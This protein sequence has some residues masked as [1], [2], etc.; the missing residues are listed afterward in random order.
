M[1]PAVTNASDS[2][3]PEELCIFDDLA[4]ALIIDPYLGFSTHK[5]DVKYKAPKFP[6]TP[7]KE[8]VMQFKSNKLS[9]QGAHEKLISANNQIKSFINRFSRRQT[10]LFKK[11]CYRYLQIFDAQ[12][13]FEIAHCPRYSQEHFLGAKLCTTRKWYKNEKVEFLIGCIAE[14][15][16]SEEQSML[17]TGVNDFSVMYSCRKN[18][19]QLWLG[20]GAFINHDCRATCK[21]VS[22]GRNTACVKILRDLDA[23]D[24]ITCHYGQNFFGDDNCYCECE[25]CERRGTGYFS[26]NRSSRP[27]NLS[28][29]DLTPNS[30]AS[31]NINSNQ[32]RSHNQ[33]SNDLKIAKSSTSAFV[34]TI[35]NG[36]NTSPTRVSQQA[37]G[38]SIGS[39]GPVIKVNYSLRETDNRLRRLKNSIKVDNT[40]NTGKL[41]NGFLQAA[42]SRQ[43]A[44]NGLAANSSSAASSSSFS[45]TTTTTTGAGAAAATANKVSVN[46][47]ATKTS[48][49]NVRGSSKLRNGCIK[50]RKNLRI[51][52]SSK[53]ATDNARQSST[54]STRSSNAEAKN[55]HH[56]HH[57]RNYS[58][59][60]HH[61]NALS[62]GRNAPKQSHVDTIMKRLSKRNLGTSLLATP[63]RLRS[64]TPTHQHQ[65][66]L[67]S[68]ISPSASK[69]S[70]P[71]SRSSSAIGTPARQWQIVTRNSS[72]RSN[73]TTTTPS[74][75]MRN[76]HHSRGYIS[77]QQ[78]QQQPQQ[79]Q[80]QQQQSFRTTR[81][82]A[83]SLN[84][85]DNLDTTDKIGVAATRSTTG[86][87][88]TG[89]GLNNE[90]NHWTLPKRVRL[91]MGDSMFVKELN[92]NRGGGVIS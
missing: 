32:L 53:R 87:A 41:T 23:G 37:V 77:Q 68:P 11:H 81:S 86:A 48:P 8:I 92:D 6:A 88:L 42:D 75:D 74:P 36:Q 20:P 31:Y 15:T 85:N 10:E 40:S 79:Q 46:G 14:L 5:M 30:K 63:A 1:S 67:R 33:T 4:T 69:S 28:P 44:I 59:S 27:N 90:A 91:K 3:T 19:A 65:T 62:S 38:A 34:R 56:H 13:G 66:R 71:V 76:H 35:M 52:F 57:H 89:A 72:S 51:T 17:K 12:S 18:R 2:M 58:N 26:T 55:H 21:F 64:A 45:S 9:Y 39:Q 24:E 7:L 61:Q 84:S 54:T 78:Q 47:M 60:N 73:S 82:R 80:Q 29:N 25:T 49:N 43:S 16:E 22:T 83:A 70:T 50:S